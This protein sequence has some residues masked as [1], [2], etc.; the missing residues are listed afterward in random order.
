[1]HPMKIRNQKKF[2]Q[3]KTRTLR[4]KRSA[5]PYMQTLLNN[6]TEKKPK[7]DGMLKPLFLVHIISSEL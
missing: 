2:K 4:Y 3:N 7:T 6:E 1:M 5:I